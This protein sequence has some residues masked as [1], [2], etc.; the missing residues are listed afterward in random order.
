MLRLRREDLLDPALPD[1]GAVAASESDVGEQ[2]D[3]IRAP[4]SGSVDQVLPL[5][6]A[7]QPTRDRDLAELELRELAV[8]VVEQ[9]LD[10]APVG[11]GTARGAREEHVVGLL[12]AQLRRRKRP[13]GPEQGIRDVRLPRPV[14][15]HD[16]GDATL[17]ANLDRIGERLEAAQLDRAEVHAG[18]TLAAEADD[19]RVRCQSGR[20]L[21]GQARARSLR[22]ALL[23]RRA[24]AEPAS[25]STRLASGESWS[26]RIAS[27]KSPLVHR[28]FLPQ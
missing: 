14:R 3:E 8:R 19:L 18:R 26:A 25:T 28:W 23:Y 2:L 16:H 10:L 1:H 9:E 22:R 11:R 27:P 4:H 21:G 24:V 12:R 15:P 20:G 17:E 7:V 5:A 13:R 6:A